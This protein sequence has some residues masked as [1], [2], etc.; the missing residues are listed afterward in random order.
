MRKGVFGAEK[1]R[2]L[3]CCGRKNGLP[4]A[5]NCKKIARKTIENPQGLLYNKKKEGE[6]FAARRS[7]DESRT[8]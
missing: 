4:T 1:G 3:R 8:R 6:V 5:K 2:G 7:Y